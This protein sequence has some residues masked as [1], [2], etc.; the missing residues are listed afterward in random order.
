M[1]IVPT[2][3][4]RP[5]AVRDCS[6]RHVRG[7]QGAVHSADSCEAHEVAAQATK[8]S[9]RVCTI[10]PNLQDH[11]LESCLRITIVLGLRR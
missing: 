7:R 11:C 10:A 9:F 6:C 5:L 1:R 3:D 4:R 8:V 2:S